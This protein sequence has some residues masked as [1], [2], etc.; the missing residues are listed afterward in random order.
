V[1]LIG[2]LVACGRHHV[3]SCD[4]DLDGVWHAPDGAWMMID[5]GVTLEAYPMTPDAPAVGAGAGSEANA[6]LVAAPRVLDLERG[7]VTL[8]G[9]MRRRFMR[10]ADTCD[11]RATVRVTACRTDMLE[12][13]T[14]AIATPIDVAPCRWPA[15]QPAHVERWTRD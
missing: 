9:T 11:A 14:T 3:A 8:A 15:P 5:N 2:V 6:A 12:V 10:R 1:S 4:D 13:V 7:E